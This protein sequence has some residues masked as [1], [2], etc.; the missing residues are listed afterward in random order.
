[1]IADDDELLDLLEKVDLGRLAVMMGSG[2]AHA[3]L[4]AVRDWS[5]MLS[6]GEQQRLAFARLLYNK[7]TLAILDESTSAL[8]LANE[9]RM[10]ALLDTLPGLSVVSVGHRP[11]LVPFH[12]TKL[13][14]ASKGFK[15]ES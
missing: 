1:S 2:D 6:L 3:G 4:G 12:D 7:P 11:S 5:D 9:E 15:L 8:D 13:I 14:L 10:F